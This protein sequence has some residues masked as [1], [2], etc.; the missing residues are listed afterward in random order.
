MNY[1]YFL[2]LAP[3]LEFM[4]AVLYAD[5]LHEHHRRNGTESWSQLKAAGVSKF[6]FFS[7]STV[8]IALSS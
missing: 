1:A 2:V 6:M 7:K 3:G 8:Q 5:G 4:A